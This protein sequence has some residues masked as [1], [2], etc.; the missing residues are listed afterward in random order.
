[1]ILAFLTLCLASSSTAVAA[2]GSRS[3]TR[4]MV[5]GT[6]NGPLAQQGRDNEGEGTRVGD[7]R[8]VRAGQLPFTGRITAQ[9]IALAITSVLVGAGLVT[10]ATPA[11]TV[12]NVLTPLG[13]RLVRAASC[14]YRLEDR[15]FDVERARARPD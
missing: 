13:D 7:G 15:L 10:T 12:R 4:T 9:W 14:G 11:R 3:S 5:A 8:R 6:S 2:T 1:M